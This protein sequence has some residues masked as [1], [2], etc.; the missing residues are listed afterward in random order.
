MLKANLT[1]TDTGFLLSHFGLTQVPIT[2]GIKELPGERYSGEMNS[3]HQY[4]GC[5]F[6]QKSLLIEEFADKSA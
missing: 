5:G 3:Q 6:L 1:P 4:T 2:Y